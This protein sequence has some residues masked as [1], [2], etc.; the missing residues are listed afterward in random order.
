M[1][2]EQKNC[3]ARVSGNSAVAESRPGLQAKHD[4]RQKPPMR[5]KLVALVV[6]LLVANL[7]GW[8]VYHRSQSDTST[9]AGA[10]SARGQSLPVP[11]VEGVVATSDV[12]I[13]LDGLGTVQAFNAAHAE[14][15]LQVGTSRSGKW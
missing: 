8:V 4:A 11:V 2:T 7:A 14:P 5:R 6:V 15:G 1:I 12:P 3:S 9:A 10:A 13:Y